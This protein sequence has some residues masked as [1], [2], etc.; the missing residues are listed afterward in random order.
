WAPSQRRG[1]LLIECLALVAALVGSSAP[2]FPPPALVLPVRLEARC[3]V[4][5]SI[6]AAPQRLT[7]RRRIEKHA[8]LLTTL[9]PTGPRRRFRRICVREP[10]SVPAGA[11]SSSDP[12]ASYPRAPRL[13]RRHISPPA[14]GPP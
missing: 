14:T 5:F 6:E 2:D 13:L 9:R 1:R 7:A 11:S 3:G 12:S 4:A 8:A 10:A